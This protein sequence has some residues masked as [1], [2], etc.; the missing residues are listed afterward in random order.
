MGPSGWNNTWFFHQPRLEERLEQLLADVS[1]VQIRRGWRVSDHESRDGREVP[2]FAGQGLGAGVRDVLNLAWKLVLALRTGADS[3]LD[4]YHAERLPH[5]AAFV[6]FSIELGRVICLTDPDAATRRDAEL[7]AQREANGE[8]PRPPQPRLGPGCHQ[9]VHG[10]ELSAQGVVDHAGGRGRLDNV[11][12]G[13]GVLLLRAA[14]DLDRID[15]DL[16]SRLVRP[17]R[18]AGGADPAGLLP[19]RHGR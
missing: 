18:R 10:G 6:D 19:V 5:A 13:P 8:P 2:P 11:L 4:T 14:A 16:Q 9:G 15:A 17:A 7:I 3:L 12:G 1:T